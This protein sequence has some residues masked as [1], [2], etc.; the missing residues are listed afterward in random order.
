MNKIG[1]LLILLIIIAIGG[2]FAFTSLNSSKKLEE[3]IKVASSDYFE[4]YVSTNETMSAYKV[5]LNELIESGEDY[6]LN[7]LNK[8]D[9]EK[10]YAVM[11]IDYKTGSPKKVE[12]ELKC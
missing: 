4:K 9:K 5:T 1:K 11:S 12:V 10:T 3:K 7:E 8:C 2:Y 6:D